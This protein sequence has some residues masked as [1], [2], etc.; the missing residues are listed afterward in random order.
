MRSRNPA[1]ENAGFSALTVKNMLSDYTS[2]RIN[3]VK[4]RMT[5]LFGS[6]S[7]EVAEAIREFAL[8]FANSETERGL[9]GKVNFEEW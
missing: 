4:K 5:A 3:D 8:A 2:E 9:T 1:V 7:P 6:K